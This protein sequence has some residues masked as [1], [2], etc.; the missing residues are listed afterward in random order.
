VGSE[1]TKPQERGKSHEHIMANHM[2]SYHSRHGILLCSGAAMNDKA[3]L[4][5]QI[6]AWRHSPIYPLQANHHILPEFGRLADR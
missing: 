6:R 4:K 5:A 1:W 3:W 2:G